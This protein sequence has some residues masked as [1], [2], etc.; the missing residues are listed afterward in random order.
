MDWSHVD[1]WLSSIFK[2]NPIP[3]FA[4]TNN[5]YQLINT[6]KNLNFNSMT[7]I[8]HILN[9]KL[10]FNL[11]KDSE[12]SIDSLAML[13]D[14]LGMDSVELTLSR[15]SMDQMKLQ[16]EF[17]KLDEMEYMLTQS[18][19]KA[20]DE[21][22]LIRSMLLNL[23][24]ETQENTV[25]QQQQNYSLSEKEILTSEYNLLQ[26]KY[27]DIGIQDSTLS[28]IYELESKADTVE[29]RCKQQEKLLE[30][31]TILPS[32]MVLASIK[33]QKTEDDLRQLEIER[34]SLLSEIANSV[35]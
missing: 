21:L 22:S 6:L 35:H 20:D 19:K 1:S 17:L 32:D 10:H 25:Q 33:I 9:N 29:S 27:N 11:S 8:Q 15:L 23:Q 7:L 26:K 31:F 30:S 16:H 3:D 14:S 34:E 13:A 5:N 4:R 2:G 24:Q 28:K 18:Q 12:K